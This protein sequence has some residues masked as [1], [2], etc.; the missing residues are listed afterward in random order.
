MRTVTGVSRIDVVPGEVFWGASGFA[1]AFD[2]AADQL[3]IGQAC[4][5]FHE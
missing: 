1:G 4:F 2:L 3:I 5:S